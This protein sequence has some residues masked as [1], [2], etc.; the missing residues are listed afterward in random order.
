MF[1]LISERGVP[2]GRTADCTGGGGFGS[3][4]ELHILDIQGVWNYVTPD[5]P[6]S[7]IALNLERVPFLWRSSGQAAVRSCW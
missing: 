3:F 1:C 6:G 5:L 2:Q 7:I 4:L